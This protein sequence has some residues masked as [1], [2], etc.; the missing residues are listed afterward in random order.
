MTCGC[1]KSARG[2]NRAKKLGISSNYQDTIQR[3]TKKQLVTLLKKLTNGLYGAELKGWTKD[4]LKQES[5]KY[6][7]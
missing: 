7:N 4:Q 5:L 3:G 2:T 1:T 6:I